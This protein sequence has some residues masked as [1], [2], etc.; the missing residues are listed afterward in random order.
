MTVELVGEILGGAF[1]R[2]VSQLPNV[3]DEVHLVTE[4]DLAKIFGTET[5][6]QITIGKLANAEGIP[7]RIDLGKLVT[8]HSAV[9]GSTGSGKS[10]TVASLLRSIVEGDVGRTANG[11]PS[12]RVLILDIHGEYGRALRDV[13]KVF[14][15]NPGAGEEPL[16]V[17][18]W[19]LEPAELMEFL[20]GR[21]D[22]KALIQVLD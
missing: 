7:I 3:N 1:E 20:L 21:I 10:T 11:F 15:I 19:A 6:G 9:L 22:E 18:Y 2:G 16:F 8:R 17:P 14:R 13:A 4:E 5:T 12:A